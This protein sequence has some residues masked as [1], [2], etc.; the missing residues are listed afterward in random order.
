MYLGKFKTILIWF[1]LALNIFLAVTLIISKSN[2]KRVDK[3]L[4]NTT[5]SLLLK[6]NI[7]IAEDVIPKTKPEVFVVDITSMYET[8]EKFADNLFGKNNYKITT[9]GF[10]S[11][12]GSLIFSENEFVLSLYNHP[13]VEISK[14]NAEK[15]IKALLK[16]LKISH[17][18]FKISNFSEEEGKKTA[19]IIKQYSGMPLLGTKLEIEISSTGVIISGFW[20]SDSIEKRPPQEAVPVYS[21]LTRLISSPDKP[22][23]AL[24]ITDI[25]PV[26][27][28]NAVDRG[29]QYKSFQAIPSV[30]IITEEGKTFFYD[31]RSEVDE[32]GSYLGCEDSKNLQIKQ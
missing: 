21:I 16:E 23:G 7:S 32:A 2:A 5:V 30:A 26:L 4:I 19:T 14:A 17:R 31:V 29:Y 22:K 24:N 3:D 20:A 27:Y 9:N 25:K 28:I 1:F 11:E 18:N 6:N 13:A 12:K 8:K 15:T 10:V